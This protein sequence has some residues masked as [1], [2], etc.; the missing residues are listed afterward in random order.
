MHLSM[1]RTYSVANGYLLHRLPPSDTEDIMRRP[2]AFYPAR[3]GQ[4]AGVLLF[5][6]ALHAAQFA[7][8]PVVKNNNSFRCNIH[9][10]QP[11]APRAHQHHDTFNIFLGPSRFS[12]ALRH[13]SRISEASQR[14]RA[15][16]MV[17]HVDFANPK[18]VHRRRQVLDHLLI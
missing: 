5:V 9:A 6:G 2:H 16:S 13:I 11:P 1:R 14:S 18:Y 8:I 10:N 7:S 17:F 3:L 4:Q 12:S 15:W